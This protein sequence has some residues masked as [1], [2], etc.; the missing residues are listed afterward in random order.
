MIRRLLPF[1]FCFRTGRAAAAFLLF[2]AEFLMGGAAGKALAQLI[3]T[4]M[5]DFRITIKTF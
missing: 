5:R 4:D 1:R 3:Y 2:S